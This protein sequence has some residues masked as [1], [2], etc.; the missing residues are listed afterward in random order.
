MNKTERRLIED[1][2]YTNQ[3][4]N[5][6]SNENFNIFY[7]YILI[8]TFIGAAVSQLVADHFTIKTSGAGLELSSIAIDGL[9]SILLLAAFIFSWICFMTYF[10]AGETQ[11]DLITRREKIKS[12]YDETEY[13]VGKQDFDDQLEYLKSYRV[14]QMIPGYIRYT[15]L[16]SGSLLFGGMFVIIS[17]T[18]AFII[19]PQTLRTWLGGYQ[20]ALRI[21]LSISI[22]LIIIVGILR[23]KQQL[24]ASSSPSK[25]KTMMGN[26]KAFF[27]RDSWKTAAGNVK[28]FCAPYWY[29]FIIPIINLL[30]CIWPLSFPPSSGKKVDYNHDQAP[31]S[32]I[33][34]VASLIG[35]IA[36][37]V[38]YLIFME[39]TR[40]EEQRLEKQKIVSIEEV[41]TKANQR[42][43]SGDK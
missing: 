12:R 41:K 4:E 29:L 23:I 30:S 1:L 26:V 13:T 38:S 10:R 11:I 6:S 15:T 2:R 36:F 8:I 37:A 18:I 43:Q 21:L 39:Y 17:S 34:V 22:L 27:S 33:Y 5:Q 24:P 25:K 40:R 32:K 42:K 9:A 16:L 14:L 28:A 31:A 3:K 35:L 20:G 7:M 19:T